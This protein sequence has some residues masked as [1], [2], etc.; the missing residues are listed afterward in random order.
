LYPSIKHKLFNIGRTMFY[1]VN[2][3]FEVPV[4]SLYNQ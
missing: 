3:V 2:A 4:K 1:Q